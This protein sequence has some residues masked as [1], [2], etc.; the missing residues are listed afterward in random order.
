MTTPLDVPAIPQPR[1]QRELIL[2]KAVELFAARGFEAMTMRLLGDAV[3]LDNSSLYRHFSGKTA[4]AGAALDR[5]AGEVL[6]LIE[7]QVAQ[8]GPVTPATL[9][10][11]AADA[12]GYFFDRPA[13]AR[14]MLHWIMS[15]GA[16]GQGFSASATDTTRPGGRL[17]EVMQQWLG[18]GARR[19]DLRRHATPDAVIIL[20]GAVLLRPATYGY[21]LASLEPT[22]SRAAARETWLLELRAAV[23]GAFAP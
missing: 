7:D 15:M 3:G 22:G 4:L 1:P 14:L 21:L 23:R 18:D 12:G 17:L 10:T 9:E 13:A 16:E 11:V 8:T 20:L 2:D 5:V 19:G 6:A